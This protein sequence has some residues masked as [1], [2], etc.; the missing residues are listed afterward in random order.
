MYSRP[1]ALYSVTSAPTGATSGWTTNS[2]LAGTMNI[3]SSNANAVREA[4]G[5]EGLLT[6]AS[7]ASGN[8]NNGVVGGAGVK[9][10]VFNNGNMAYGVGVLGDIESDAGTVGEYIMGD[11]FSSEVLGGA[12][13]NAL[14]GLWGTAYIQSATVPSITWCLYLAQ[15]VGSGSTVRTVTCMVRISGPSWEVALLPIDIFYTSIRSIQEHRRATILACIR[16]VQRRRTS[17]P[18]PSVLVV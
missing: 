12:V 16:M 3:P 6:N 10:R 15:D 17:S 11:Y 7:T 2:A 5:L 14:L 1:G 18:G 8:F 4:A 13:Q 9:G